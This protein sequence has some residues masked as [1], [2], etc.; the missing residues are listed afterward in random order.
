MPRTYLSRPEAADYIRAR[1]LIIAKTTLQKYATVGGG[2]IVY[3]QTRCLH[4]LERFRGVGWGILFLKP[5]RYNVRICLIEYGGCR[6]GTRR[7]TRNES[8]LM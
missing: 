1:G 8:K 2:P 4:H 5:S 3:S 6:L 7:R